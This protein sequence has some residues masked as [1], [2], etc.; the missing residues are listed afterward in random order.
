MQKNVEMPKK[1]MKVNFS[2]LRLELFEIQ[3]F[4]HK[5]IL[6]D[7]K[8]KKDGRVGLIGIKG[9]TVAIAYDINIV[10]K[11]DSFNISMQMHVNKQKEFGYELEVDAI[12]HFSFE[13]KI[14]RYDKRAL[15]ELSAPS[16]MIG[17]IRGYL[18]N[19]TAYGSFGAYILPSIDA[20]DL[21]LNFGGP[22]FK[23]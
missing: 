18:Q 20:T 5:T 7:K 6:V 22:R 8:E 13:G 11:D 16:I 1:Q 21:D 23:K 4:S 15:M 2:E 17:N 9:H 3:N 10:G 19:V 12:G 14:S